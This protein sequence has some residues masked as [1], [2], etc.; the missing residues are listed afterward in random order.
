MIEDEEDLNDAEQKIFFLKLQRSEIKI[1][2]EMI[3]REEAVSWFWARF[4]GFW[5]WGLAGTILT[6]FAVY[7]KIWEKFS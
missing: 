7:E 5:K 3:A 4:S 6:G 1:L 2:R